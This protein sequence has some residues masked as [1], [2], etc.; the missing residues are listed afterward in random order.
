MADS[1]SEALV[2]GL[3]GDE[4][5]RPRDDFVDGLSVSEAVKEAVDEF[6]EEA[7]D[8]GLEDDDTDI[9]R[10]A[11]TDDDAVGLGIEVAQVILFMSIMGICA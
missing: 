11:V 7:D 4:S 5:G 6:D 8:S 9:E 10:V 2:D 3:V 1:D